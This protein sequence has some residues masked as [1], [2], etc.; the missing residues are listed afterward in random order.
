M[1]DAEIPLAVRP[2]NPI[3]VAQNLQSLA[4]AGIQQQQQQQNLQTGAIRQRED[5]LALNQAG[6]E[7]QNA[8]DSRAAMAAAVDPATG[9]V[10]RGILLSTLGKLNP[11]VAAQTA[12]T[13]QTQDIAA[14]EAQ[15]KSQAAQLALAEAHVNAKDKL[16]SGV[17]D[18]ITYT[19]AVNSG[20]QAGIVKPGELP[21]QYDPQLVAQ[22]HAQ[23]LSQQEQISNMQAAQKEKDAAA[24]A[25]AT[26]ANTQQYQKSQLGIRRGELAVQ[27]G[28]LAVNQQKAAANALPDNSANLT[29]DAYLATLPAG[30][31]N[32]IKST[33]NGDIAIPSPTN[34]SP[35]AQA[36]REGVLSYDPTY[37]DA[38]YK[39]KQNFKT[40]PDAAAIQGAAT[41]LAHMDNALSSSAAVG[42]APALDTRFQTPTDAAYMKDAQV[43]TGE[44]GKLVT[45]K[46][47]TVDEGNKLLSG[48]NSFRQD[49]R[50]SAL[51]ELAKD[52]ADRIRAGFQKY[53]AATGQ[54][55]PINEF[56]DAP[57]QAKLSKLGIIQ[58]GAQP[59]QSGT[60]GL[61]VKLSD[62]MALPAN[63]GKTAQQVAA[64]IQAHG[65]TVIQ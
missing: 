19:N 41:M 12:Q 47:L 29:G 56:F 40:G 65:H 22:L 17:N 9:K 63:A 10:D 51:N 39:G 57:T 38:R 24:Q 3:G 11:T 23:T 44:V 64:D 13:L 7:A 60:S 54:D 62:A 5:Q 48:L 30:M 25:Q 59:A 58:G 2:A 37:T 15:T 21:A 52:S 61:G 46:A 55:L 50:D 32:L 26:L 35:Q 31:Q 33:A 42:T 14:Q 18:Q 6:Q 1:I 20:I 4:S 53:K 28:N 34:R 8:A 36:V 43:Y 27:Q 49:V 16:L 45:A